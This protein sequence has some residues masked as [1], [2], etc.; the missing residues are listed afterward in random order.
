[1]GRGGRV[2]MERKK[3][4]WEKCRAQLKTKQ[5]LK[6]NFNSFASVGENK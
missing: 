5:N 6:N 2:K 4:E 1:M 3:G